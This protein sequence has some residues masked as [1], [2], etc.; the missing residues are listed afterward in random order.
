MSQIQY[1]Y[2]VARIRALE[3]A[4]FSDSVIEQLIACKDEETSLRFLA[5]R[6]WGGPEDALDA[7]AMLLR[8]QE[9][10]WETVQGLNADMKIFDVLSYA[11][12][13][14]NLK[15]AVKEAYVGK[16]YS[17]IFYSG[18]GCDQDD[19]RRIIRDKDYQALPEYMREC[20]KEAADTLS[21]SGDGQ[22][23]D[24]IIDRAALEAIARVGETSKEEVVRAYAKTYV[25]VSNIKIAA[26]CAKT[27][28][29]SKFIRRALAD[30][31]DID[32]EGLAGSAASGMQNLL[33]F[34]RN[35]GYEQAAD[36]LQESPS[37]FECWCD[38]SIIRSIQPQ[39]YNPFSAGPLLAYVIARENEIKTV[40]I[41]LTCRQNKLSDEAIR[42]RV[43]EMYV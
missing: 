9:K 10:I 32:T 20:A 18:A 6:G 38:N 33:E 37:A 5:D 3:V 35:S 34:L 13:F 4:L 17:N 1:A 40:R 16:S 24:M 43:R 14:H 29:N 41:I 2:A 26:R 39:K 22:V 31:K 28:K 36:K 8:E 7:E 30:C 42:E 12:A 15:A 27:G 23:C 21:H 25:A 11:N 19:M